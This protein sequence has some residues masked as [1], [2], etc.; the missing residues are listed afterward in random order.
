MTWGSSGFSSLDRH[1]LASG[2]FS[3]HPNAFHAKLMVMD[4]DGTISTEV[5]LFN[6]KAVQ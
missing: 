4:F 1:S 3:R 6:K 5:A 2:H